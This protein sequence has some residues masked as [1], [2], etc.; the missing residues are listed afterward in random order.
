MQC[1]LVAPQNTTI[2]KQLI[3]ISCS[4]SVLMWGHDRGKDNICTLLVFLCDLWHVY[5]PCQVRPLWRVVISNP[6]SGH[7]NW[8]VIHHWTIDSVCSCT[9][10][11]HHTHLIKRTELSGK[12]EAVM[13]GFYVCVLIFDLNSSPNFLNHV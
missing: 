11:Q 6:R 12:E 3:T 2:T 4:T 7:L 5:V 8:S 13:T 1:N 10:T 9:V